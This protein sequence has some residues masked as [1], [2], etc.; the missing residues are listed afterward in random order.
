MKT[1]PG[2][3]SSNTHEALTTRRGF[4]KGAAATA[5]LLTLGELGRVGA[6]LSQTALPSPDASG[7]EHII[8]LM[9]ENRS[10]DHYLG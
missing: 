8:V 9:M 1:H 4:L 2:A 3:E 10:F 7:I 5:G 6:A